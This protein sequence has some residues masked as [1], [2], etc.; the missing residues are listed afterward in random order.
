MINE[1]KLADLSA[2]SE[3]HEQDESLS[4]DGD[5]SSPAVSQADSTKQYKI[6]DVLS[7]N[8]S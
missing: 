3:E 1:K 5:H 4:K 7:E 6:G 8:K 2:E